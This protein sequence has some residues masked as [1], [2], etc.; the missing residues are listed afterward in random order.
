VFDALRAKDAPRDV[1]GWVA[2]P[3]FEL[4]M[5]GPASDSW[6]GPIG[7]R[8]P[9]RSRRLRGAI[10]DR[11]DGGSILAGSFVGRGRGRR[12]HREERE[13]RAWLE[14]LL[15]VGSGRDE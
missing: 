10:A 7:W 14:R 1:V 8:A 5:R 12:D 11:P 4:V 15:D 2:D 6:L 3:D 13:L 9:A